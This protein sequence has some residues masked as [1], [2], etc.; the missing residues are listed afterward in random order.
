MKG[1]EIVEAREAAGLTQEQLAQLVGVSIRT[2]GNWERGTTV[3]KNRLGRLRKVLADLSAS[4]SLA[5]TAT[6]TADGTVGTPGEDQSSVFQPRFRRPE[7]ISD[8]E[9]ERMQA[10]LH[11]YWE[12]IADE[13]AGER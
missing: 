11:G 3:P 4:A 9:W 8:A 1:A 5:V 12:A 13:V 7:G 6:V 10:R 2:I